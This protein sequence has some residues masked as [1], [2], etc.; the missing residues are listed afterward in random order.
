[1][2]DHTHTFTGPLNKSKQ[3][4][5][6]EDITVALA[7]PE[8]GKKDKIFKRITRHFKQHPELKRDPRFEG[9]F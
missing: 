4:G 1:R 8:H 7:L 5:D 3:K 6:L 9:L 2:A